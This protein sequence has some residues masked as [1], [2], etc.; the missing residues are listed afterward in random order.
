MD[1]YFFIRS[2]IFL[3]AGLVVVIFPQVVFNM[4]SRAVGYLVDN[5]HLGIFR[6]MKDTSAEKVI[7]TNRIMGIV[8]IVISVGLF[9]VSIA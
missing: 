8:F 2:I 9:F 7:R 6:S 4:Q 1:I 5:L 3:V